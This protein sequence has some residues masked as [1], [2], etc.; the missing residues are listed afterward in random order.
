M[1]ILLSIPEI[2]ILIGIFAIVTELFIGIE[3]GFDFVL[4]GTSLI[5]GGFF[6]VLADNVVLSLVISSILSALYIF[7]GR[8]AIRQKV[9]VLT[10]KTNIDKLVGKSATVV[11]TITPD[12]AGM[13]RLDD[14]DWRA[15]SD[16]V[17]YERDK[18]K[19][20]SIEG[21]TLNVTKIR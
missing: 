12:T 15:N 20:L 13:V 11:R 2:L 21:V 16:E 5:L 14:E 7:V 6:G 18:V 9:Y 19:I 1:P 17:I 4:I 3:E 8:N 10:H